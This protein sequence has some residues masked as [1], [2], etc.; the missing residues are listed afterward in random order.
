MTKLD[1]DD[2]ALRHASCVM[3][4]GASH[5]IRCRAAQSPACRSSAPLTLPH[6]TGVCVH[7]SDCPFTESPPNPSVLVLS[8][9]ALNFLRGAGC[10]VQVGVY[11][12]DH[13]R[14]PRAHRRRRPE[15]EGAIGSH[16]S[17]A[18]TQPVESP[19]PSSV[20]LAAP[21]LTGQIPHNPAPVAVGRRCRPLGQQSCRKQRIE[22]F[23]LCT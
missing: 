17:L 4:C 5:S 23:E 21:S 20:S 14:G 11:L 18:H 9:G 1:D 8:L 15:D 12:Q 16:L 2:E 22:R 19:S 6:R 3:Q 13:H 10:S 7:Q